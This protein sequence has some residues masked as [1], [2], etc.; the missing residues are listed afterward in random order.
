MSQ[1][2]PGNRHQLKSSVWRLPGR[3]TGPRHRR[4]D[5]CSSVTHRDNSAN[6]NRLMFW[7]VSKESVKYLLAAHNWII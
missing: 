6:A 4:S 2:P 5:R 1:V 3:Q 7:A